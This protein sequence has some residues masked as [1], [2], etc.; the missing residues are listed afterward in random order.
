LFESFVI[1]MPFGDR[2]VIAYQGETWRQ[3][4]KMNCRDIACLANV[5]VV[6]SGIQTDGAAK[7]KVGYGW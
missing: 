3:L 1:S 5:H 2:I 6:A 4:F 7:T